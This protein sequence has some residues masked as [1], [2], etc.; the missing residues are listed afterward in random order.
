M[1]IA[2][3]KLA[4]YIQR[5]GNSASVT[6]LDRDCHLFFLPD[7]EGVIGYRLIDQC[8]VVFG[9]PICAAKDMPQLAETFARFCKEQEWHVVYMTASKSF[10]EWSINKICSSLMEVGEELQLNPSN[11]PFS[12]RKSRGL[13]NK[14]NLAARAQLEVLEYKGNDPHLEEKI[15]QVGLNWIKGRQ[16]P[17]IFFGQMRV[18]DERIGKRWFYAK[19][20]QG[21]VGVMILQQMEARQGWLVQFLMKTLDAPKG[22]TEQ[23]VISALNVLRDEGAR[24]L[25]FGVSQNK[26]V[27]EV[28]GLGKISEWI[29]RIVFNISQKLFHLDRR[30]RFW[31]KFQPEGEPSYLLF[32]EPGIGIKDVKSVMRALNVSL[33]ESD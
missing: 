23:L 25:S 24:S 14:V 18:F 1:D 6:I 11:N 15:R 3:D 2:R 20:E 10:A 32:S 16:G 8:A 4:E 9:D 27:G 22:T 13:R 5:W 7:I 12:G 29:V 30:R 21:I 17:Q 19:N 31:R 28:Q 26:R 33:K